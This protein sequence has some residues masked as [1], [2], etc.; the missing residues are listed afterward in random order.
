MA[1][2]MQW[3]ENLKVLRELNEELRKRSMVMT[4]YERQKV[5]SQRNSLRKSCHLGIVSGAS[6]YLTGKIN[7]FKFERKLYEKARSKEINSWDSAI[8]S[9]TYGIMSVLLNMSIVGTNPMIGDTKSNRIRKL[10]KEAVDS[11]DKYRLRAFNDLLPGITA[12]ITNDL[13]ES[14]KVNAVNLESQTLVDKLRETEE[15]KTARDKAQNAY[16]DFN[17][18]LREVKNISVDIG[19]GEIDH[20]LATGQLADLYHRIQVYRDE[21]GEPVIELLEKDRRF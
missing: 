18:S 21:Q 10:Y 3:T 13:E 14:R 7:A 16:E 6:D 9:S 15:I 8:L 19:D 17:K 20:P 12:K 1:M 11:G 5:E 2:I 4:P